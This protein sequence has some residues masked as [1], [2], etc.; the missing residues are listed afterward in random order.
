MIHGRIDRVA[1]A[2]AVGFLTAGALLMGGGVASAT[3]PGANNAIV[4][5]SSCSDG[6]AIYSVPLGTTNSECPPG[7]PPTNP[8]Y[9]Q[10]TAGSIDAMPFFSSSGGTLYFSADR[11]SPGNPGPWSIYSVAYPSTPSS[12]LATLAT[13]PSGYN[14]FAPTVTAATSTGS[15]LDFIQCQGTSSPC[16]LQ[17]ETLSALGV[18]T[19]SPVQISTGNCP[20]PAGPISS[21]DGQSNRPEWNPTNPNQLV[22]VG[23]NPTTS[24]DNIYLLT[25]AAAGNSCTDLSTTP[26]IIPAVQT[27]TANASFGDQ[28]P[29]WSPDGTQIVF[30]STRTGG[31]K[32]YLVDPANN[33]GAYQVWG[34]TT[35][36][37]AG[38]P[39]EE[40]EPVY[41]P[42]E[43]PNG[44][45]PK[46]AYPTGGSAS[47]YDQPM[48]IWVL[49]G[50]GDNVQGDT[51]VDD[52]TMYSSPTL[53]TADYALN[54]DPIWQPLGL[55]SPLPE[56]SYPALLVGVGM[57]TL[58][59]GLYLRR[60]RAALAA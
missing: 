17:E 11:G 60:R 8:A 21:T 18:P 10:S 59:G 23:V 31:T 38:D 35:T 52:G 44:A 3:F 20:A 27:Y 12:A 6:E 40:V 13:P 1:I 22:Y 2:A 7:S 56:A 46:S 47:S 41:A 57:I 26:T 19:E 49:T 29:D 36:N 28:D 55:G 33:T 50:G 45:Y 48:L 54:V 42:S 24:T 43:T 5:A 14:D 30:D 51:T 4:F 16:T 15:T 32:L 25:L 53:V 34:G 37:P 39:G 9:T 58:A